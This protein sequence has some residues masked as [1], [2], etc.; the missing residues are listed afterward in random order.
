MIPRSRRTHET[1]RGEHTMSSINS[2]WNGKKWRDDGVTIRM[3]EKNVRRNGRS[4]KILFNF[5]MNRLTSGKSTLHSVWQMKIT[6]DNVFP[7]FFSAF[8]KWTNAIA[9]R[10]VNCQ[11]L[12]CSLDSDTRRRHTFDCSLSLDDN[13]KRLRSCS[14]G[15]LHSLHETNAVWAEAVAKRAARERLKIVFVFMSTLTSHRFRYFIS[16][17]PFLT[18]SQLHETWTTIKQTNN[19]NTFSAFSNRRARIIWIPMPKR[20]QTIRNFERNEIEQ[21]RLSRQQRYWTRE[22]QQQK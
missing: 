16:I 21:S 18:H 19:N 22:S 5:L 14:C 12:T 8:R 20:K 17:W 4:V 15:L 10:R 6:N 13:K 1:C 9:R 11:R 7:S 3:Q 2:S